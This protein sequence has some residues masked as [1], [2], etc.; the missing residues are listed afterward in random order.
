MMPKHDEDLGSIGEKDISRQLG[1]V[2]ID[3]HNKDKNS[4]LFTAKNIPYGREQANHGKQNNC[5]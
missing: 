2:R 5:K 1:L 4:H 3:S